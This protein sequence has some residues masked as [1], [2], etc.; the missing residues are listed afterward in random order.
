[1]TPGASTGNTQPRE[2]S[3]AAPALLTPASSAAH[4]P[5]MRVSARFVSWL[6]DSDGGDGDVL[7]SRYQ[8]HIA[9][10]AGHDSDLVVGGR[11]DDGTY[12]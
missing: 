3:Q 11:L 10:V 1:M 7:V 6:Q 5:P 8:S 9:W 12:V 2:L 4:H